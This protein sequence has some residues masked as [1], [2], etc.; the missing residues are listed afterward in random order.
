MSRS[1][2]AAE[3]SGIPRGQ[4]APKVEV[5]VD[6]WR[7]EKRVGDDGPI[8]EVIEGGK[9]IQTRVIYR[10]PGQP[11]HTYALGIPVAPGALDGPDWE[12][13]PETQE[14]R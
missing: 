4:D 7:C 14:E 5:E 1:S 10:R 11:L 2:A 3:Q 12:D 9:D 6:H 13:R 8:C